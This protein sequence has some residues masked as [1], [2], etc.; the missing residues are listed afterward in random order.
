MIPHTVPNRPMYGVMLAVVARNGTRLS[1]LFTSTADARSSARSSAGEASKSRTRRGDRLDLAGS[2]PDATAC[3]ARRNRPGRSR[4]AGSRQVLADRLYFRELA[5][6]AEDIEKGG[7]LSLSAVERPQ[8]V[9]ND[10][11]GGD[12]EQDQDQQNELRDWILRNE[13]CEIL[14]PARTGFSRALHLQCKYVRTEQAQQSLRR[15]S[16]APLGQRGSSLG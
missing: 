4:R 6:A 8:F 15:I 12:G 9:E 16:G 7:R 14:C 13:R 5:A 1:S 10:A 2:A 11:P 3:S